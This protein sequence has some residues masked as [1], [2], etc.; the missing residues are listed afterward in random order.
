MASNGCPSLAAAAQLPQPNCPSPTA[1]AQ[2]NTQL[3][4]FSQSYNSLQFNVLLVIIMLFF[5][6]FPHSQSL[7]H[8]SL[9]L[10]LSLPLFLFL[11]FSVSV[12]CLPVLWPGVWWRVVASLVCGGIPGVAAS[13]A[14]G[15]IWRA[16]ASLD[17]QFFKR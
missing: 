2:L 12:I 14:C 5:M 15:G 9:F 17:I 4:F 8:F 10:Y 13:L 3:V 11:S 16:G 6:H 1:P 7:S